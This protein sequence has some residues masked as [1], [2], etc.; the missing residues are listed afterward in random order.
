[1]VMKHSIIRFKPDAAG[2]R[3]DGRATMPVTVTATTQ[4]AR[5]REAIAMGRESGSAAQVEDQ[6]RPRHFGVEKNDQ[7]GRDIRAPPPLVAPGRLRHAHD[8]QEP[9]KTRYR[10]K[11]VRH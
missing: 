11:R 2:D 10:R 5:Y 9:P 8:E 6:A 7:E 3:Q 4:V 1:M